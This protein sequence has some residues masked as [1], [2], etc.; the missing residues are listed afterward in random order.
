MRRLRYLSD[1]PLDD[2]SRDRLDFAAYAEALSAIIDS[3]GTDTPLSLAISAPWGAGKTSLAQLVDRDLRSRSDARAGERPTITCWF[4]A[5]MHDDAP[6]LG[7]AMAAAV[8]ADVSRRRS[9]WR[10]LAQ[11]VPSIL[12]TPGGRFGRRLGLVLA[13]LVVVGAILSIR[14][15]REALGG[16]KVVE[17][18]G[19]ADAGSVAFLTVAALFLLSR[20][21]SMYDGVARFLADPGREAARGSIGTVRKQLGGLIEQGIHRGRLVVFVDDL[22]RCAPARAIDVCEIAA[23]L[24]AHDGVVVVFIADMDLIARSAE[25]RYGTESDAEYEAGRR[26]LEKIVQIQ[27]TLPPPREQDMARV[28]APP[29]P[30]AVDAPDTEDKR[31]RSVGAWFRSWKEARAPWLDEPK[32][33]VPFLFLLVA[34]FV[35]WCHVVGLVVYESIELLTLQPGAS[36]DADTS[37]LEQVLGIAPG[38]RS[39]EV[40]YVALM[41]SMLGLLTCLAAYRALDAKRRRSVRNLRRAIGETIEAKDEAN[42]PQD[43]LEAAVI[44]EHPK[45]EAIVR[46]L[47]GTYLIDAAEQLDDVERVI[48]DYPPSLPRGA[49]RMLNHARLLT[50]IARARRM[51]DQ[52]L[53]PEH[54]GEWIVINERWRPLARRI[55][56]DPTVLGALETAAGHGETKLA[57]LLPDVPM[58]RAD[59]DALLELLTE[60]PLLGAVAERLVHFQ[61]APVPARSTV[62]EEARPAGF[63]PATSRS[64]GERSIH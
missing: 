20:L 17:D 14:S 59:T 55:E 24:L 25:K 8:A 33:I 45:H 39:F 58:S 60:P 49:K 40:G 34:A 3:R 28:L 32:L 31:T 57:E 23:Q 5:G 29:E 51:F 9:L 61:P 46:E 4:N 2:P 18:S 42:V 62:E 22:E 12:L 50:Q 63:E 7:A 11:P 48:L 38:S 21:Q 6:H 52:D 26:F 15:V 35:G 27:L 43:R 54:L 56:S 19:F 41:A 37:T 13:A 30:G 36:E 16:S 53:T 47:V 1:S 64:G 44:E 10:K